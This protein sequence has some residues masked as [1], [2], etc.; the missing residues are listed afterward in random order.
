MCRIAGI[1]DPTLQNLS[2]E[3]VKMNDAMQHGG[4]DDEGVYI[5]TEL[6]NKKTP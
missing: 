1:F 4:P 6:T 3:I 5:Y 2:Q